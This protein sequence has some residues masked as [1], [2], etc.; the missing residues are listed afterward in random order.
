MKNQ[1]IT[2]FGEVLFDQF[3][4]GSCVLGGAPF[5][6]AWH[7]QAFGLHPQCISRVGKDALGDKIRETLQRWGMS[8]AFLQQDKVYP[9]GLVQVEV[10]QGEP[11]FS[12]LPDQAYDYIELRGLD[13]IDHSGLFYHGSLAV[14]SATS[15]HT[16]SLLKQQHQGKIFMDVNLRQ[17]WWN[18]ADVLALIGDADW[19]KLNSHELQALVP[20]KSDLKTSMESL[21]SQYGLEGI[22]VTRGQDGALALDD[23]GRFFSVS[24]TKAVAVVDT[25]GAGDAFQLLSCLGCILAGLWRKLWKGHNSSRRERWQGRALRWKRWLFIVSLSNRGNC[26]QK[27]LKKRHKKTGTRPVSYGIT[28]RLIKYR[29]H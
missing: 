9:T 1:A 14:R 22:I 29:P 17:P 18:K 21:L 2:V 11:V 5:N 4:D 27:F 19:V 26:N 8:L 13:A 23:T 12:I 20:D 10:G 7:L 15:R 16:L 24:P 3:P 25:V 28:G 6:V